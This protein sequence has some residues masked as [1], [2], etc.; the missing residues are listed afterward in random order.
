[1]AQK[2]INVAAN[3]DQANDVVNEAIVLL[4]GLEEYVKAHPEL[5]RAIVDQLGSILNMLSKGADNTAD[6]VARVTDGIGDFFAGR[7]VDLNQRR[8]EAARRETTL[9]VI[10]SYYHLGSKVFE[11]QYASAKKEGIEF[12]S[13]P[14]CYVVVLLPHPMK[15]DT[16]LKGYV[17]AHVGSA[18]KDVGEEIHRQLSGHGNYDVYADHKYKAECQ[19]IYIMPIGDA[20]AIEPQREKLADLFERDEATS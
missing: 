15:N 19:Y 1:M 10:E 11:E 17:M 5:A 4:D 20:S 12:H 2:K 13:S 3:I 16:D 7:T 18:E 9:G 8:E 14:G 6:A